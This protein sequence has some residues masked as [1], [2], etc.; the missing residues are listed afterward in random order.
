MSLTGNEIILNNESYI[1]V[2]LNGIEIYVGKLLERKKT[3]CY[4]HG[5]KSNFNNNFIFEKMPNRN[6]VS[7]MDTWHNSKLFR[8]F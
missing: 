3:Y 4:Y 6:D 1:I 7:P 2:D 8:V 5:T